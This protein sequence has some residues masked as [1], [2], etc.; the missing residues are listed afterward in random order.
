MTSG[1]T[2]YPVAMLDAAS[3][4]DFASLAFSMHQ[5]GLATLGAQSPYLA[6]GARFLGQPVGLGMARVGEDATQAAILSLA[7]GDAFQ[8]RG[9]AT[10]LLTALQHGL[11]DRGCT[12]F[13]IAYSSGPSS[14]PAL[15]RILQKCGWPP[16]Q[17]DRVLFKALM[18]A[19]G[20]TWAREP[21]TFPPD[22]ALFD[23]CD[24]PPTELA[25]LQ[26]QRQS[27]PR[28]ADA[29]WNPALPLEPL[30]SLGLRH[31]GE[32]VGWLHVRRA[33]PDAVVYDNLWMR[34][35]MRRAGPWVS[36]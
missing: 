1:G 6:V 16:S 12:Q 9:V 14:T 34:R 23:W 33:A 13:H 27:D 29:L 5:A 8:G 15:E 26:Q 32:I 30:E 10:A 21:P 4:P 7:V 31:A 25:V 22:L 19:D 36:A 24:L 28:Y 17:V 3:G 2:T 35:D 20:I 11:R 18:P